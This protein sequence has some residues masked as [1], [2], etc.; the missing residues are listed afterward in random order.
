MQISVLSEML[1]SFGDDCTLVA[2]KVMVKGSKTTIN[3]SSLLI[4]LYVRLTSLVHDTYSDKVSKKL[5]AYQLCCLF[6]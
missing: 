6:G 2:I 3:M 1:I 5:H 4:Y